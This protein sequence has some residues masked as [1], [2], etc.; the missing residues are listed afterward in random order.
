MN[1]LP[2]TKKMRVIYSP[3]TAREDQVKTVYNEFFLTSS[4]RIFLSKDF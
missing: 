1:A 3:F 2:L 4:K